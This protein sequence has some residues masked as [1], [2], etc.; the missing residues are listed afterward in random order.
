[1]HVTRLIAALLLFWLLVTRS[2]EPL[3]TLGVASGSFA[4]RLMV[5]NVVLAITF[6]VGAILGASVGGAINRV[7][8]ETSPVLSDAFITTIYSLML[9]FLGLYAMTDFLRARRS[10]RAADGPHGASQAG[11]PKRVEGADLGGLSQRLQAV[12]LPPMIRFDHDF[13]GADALASAAP[14]TTIVAFAVISA[15]IGTSVSSRA[16]STS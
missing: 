11:G 7:L 15:R 5:V 6:L 1:M 12:N 14:S 10:Q 2:F 9:G 8:Y 3:N 13:I 16:I 4:E